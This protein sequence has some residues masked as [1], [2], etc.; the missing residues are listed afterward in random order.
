[1]KNKLRYRL[2]PG[3]DDAIFCERIP[4]FLDDSYKLYGSHTCIFNGKS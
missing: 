2:I 3:K 1:M 4:K